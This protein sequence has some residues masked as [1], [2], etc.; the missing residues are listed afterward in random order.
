MYRYRATLAYDGTAY[1]GW[2]KTK[3]GPSIQETLARKIHILSPNSPLPEAASR[4]DRG[5]HAEGQVVSLDIEKPWEPELLL[6]ALNAHL[7]S[8]IRLL[9]LD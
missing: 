7:P 6:R 4:T 9:T 3:E 8:D 2:Q 1:L 5:V